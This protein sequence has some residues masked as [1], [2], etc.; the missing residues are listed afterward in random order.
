MPSA[1]RLP[2]RI[3]QFLARVAYALQ[4][5]FIGTCPYG[6]LRRAMRATSVA[7]PVLP[8]LPCILAEGEVLP[9]AEAVVFA[10]RTIESALR[11]KAERSPQ[12][13]CIPFPSARHRHYRLLTLTEARMGCHESSPAC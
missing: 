9:P 1:L 5:F 12:K 6:Y 11:D 2:Y 8:F 4:V 3:G 7:A 10:L 13:P